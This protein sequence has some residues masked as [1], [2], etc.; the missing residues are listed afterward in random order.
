MLLFLFS[1]LLPAATADPKE[2]HKRECTFSVTAV[3]T[4][5]CASL[6]SD[7]G[8]TQ[9]Q[10]ISFNPT[11]GPG[12]SN[13]LTTGANYCV[14]WNGPLPSA[15][16]STSSVSSTTV[17]TSTLSTETTAPSTAPSPTQTGIVS[18]CKFSSVS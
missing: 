16:T 8:I 15:E 10:F 6:A 9:D 1:Y 17:T 2:I 7:W 12:C 4:D 18:D 5:S 11:V 14:E 13:G 3:A